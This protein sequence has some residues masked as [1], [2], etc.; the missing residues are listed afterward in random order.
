MSFG[1]YQI[2]GTHTRNRAKMNKR[3]NTIVQN[4]QHGIIPTKRA[5]KPDQIDQPSPSTDHLTSGPTRPRPRR[6]RWP[7]TAIGGRPTPHGRLSRWVL[8]GTSFSSSRRR[9]AVFPYLLKAE[10]DVWSYIKSLHTPS[11]GIPIPFSYTSRRR[12]SSSVPLVSLE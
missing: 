10:T 8:A 12:S 6:R 2:A 5:H 1:D 7:E 3:R 4:I 9:L 11:Q